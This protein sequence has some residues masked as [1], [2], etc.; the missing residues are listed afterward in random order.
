[1]RAVPTIFRRELISFFYSPIAYIVMTVFLVISGFF[2]FANVTRMAQM[3]LGY[4]MRGQ[5]YNMAIV[6]LFVSP[7]ITMRLLAEEHR[8]GTME[9][10]MTA[11]VTD[12]EVV[13][14]KYLA[15]VAF[16]IAMLIPTLAYPLTLHIVGSPDWGPIIAGYI[17]IVLVGCFFLAVG[18]LTSAFTRNQIIAAIMAFVILLI[19][20]LLDIVSQ[21]TGD[22]AGSVLKYITIFYHID[23][24]VKGLI[25]SR[26]V[27]Y[28]LSICAFCLFATVR[29]VESR[30][31]R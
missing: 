2:F 11:P 10:L 25:D 17:G 23:S 8:S 4:A 28:Y 14:G 29:V 27:V 3:D 16:Y 24:F 31:W 15:S 20:W 12:F 9:T 19:M 21:G 7:M 22:A 13:F 5:F 26:D 6:F 1:M 30:K 18:L